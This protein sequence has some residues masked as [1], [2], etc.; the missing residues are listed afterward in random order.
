[1]LETTGSRTVLPPIAPHDLE[2]HRTAELIVTNP[3]DTGHAPRTDQLLDDESS[4][5]DLAGLKHVV[6]ATFL[7]VSPAFQSL[8]PFQ[9]ESG[10]EKGSPILICPPGPEFDA[11]QAAGQGDFSLR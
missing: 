8:I 1:M 7:H 6:R 4:I 5:D 2:R 11:P 10:W 3:I 9:Y